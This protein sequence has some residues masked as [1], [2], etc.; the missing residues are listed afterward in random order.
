MEITHVTS[1]L[2]QPGKNVENPPESDG[3]QLPLEGNLFEMLKYVFNRSDRECDI[4]IRFLSDDNINQNNEVRN[5]LIDLLKYS[6]IEKG[7][8]LANRLRD[9]TTW[10]SGLGLLFLILGHDEDKQDMKVVLSRF[11]ADRGILAEAGAD[12]LKLE[13]IERIFMKSSTTYKAALYRGDS[14]EGGFWFGYA[15]DKQLD[16]QVANYW[17]RDFLASDLKTTSKAGTKRFAIA[18]RDATKKAPSVDVQQELIGLRILVGGLSG[19][20]V[21]IKGVMDNFGLCDDARR[22]ITKQLP[23]K[24]LITDKFVLDREEF[25]RHAPFTSVELHTGCVLLAP[26]D[27]FNDV[28]RRQ[29]IDDEMKRYQ[30]I[31]EGMIIDERIRGRK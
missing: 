26:S 25:I 6:T 22:T 14:L 15:V 31:A 10:K 18:I 21:S 8:P 24:G 30:F 12:G 23:H 17:I 29:T 4:P 27:T 1:F 16:D 7:I 19:K 3:T 2:V 28:F 20:S 5:M 9:F 11:P 13:F